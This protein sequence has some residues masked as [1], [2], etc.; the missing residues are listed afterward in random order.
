VK[1]DKE[2]FIGR[3][4]LRRVKE[5]GPTRRL[6][7]LTPEAPRQIP[8]AGYAVLDGDR[9]VGKVTSGTFA[10]TLGRGLAMGYVEADRAGKGRKL[11]VD[12]RGKRAEAAVTPL[13]FYRGGSRRK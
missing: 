8:R 10:P 9:E 6:V 4:R 13:P 3:E 1:L 11:A 7:G 5:A 12:I 2:D